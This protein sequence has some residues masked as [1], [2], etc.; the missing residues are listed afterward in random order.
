MVI[1]P[2]HPVPTEI[3][4]NEVA[5]TDRG[6]QRALNKVRANPNALQTAYT[7]TLRGAQF[8]FILD[9]HGAESDTRERLT[10]ASRCAVAIFELSRATTENVIIELNET[11]TV[12]RTGPGHWSRPSEWIGAMWLAIVA[13]NTVG[14]QL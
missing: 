9:P 1:I 5:R 2:R 3:A 4:V 7:R 13:G 14:E 12:R 6:S 8:K 10:L 11:E